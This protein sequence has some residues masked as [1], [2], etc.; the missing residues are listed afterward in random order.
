MV[1]GDLLIY[2]F[3]KIKKQVLRR[4]T[5]VSKARQKEHPRLEPRSV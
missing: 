3:F 2:L 5:N 1:S 4:L